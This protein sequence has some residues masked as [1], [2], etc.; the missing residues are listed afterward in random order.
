MRSSQIFP[1]S[2]GKTSGRVWLLPPSV[3]DIERFSR[4]EIESLLV[5]SSRGI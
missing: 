3:S 2:N 1:I 4:D 5:L